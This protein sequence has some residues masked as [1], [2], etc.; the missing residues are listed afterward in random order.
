MSVHFIYN[1]IFHNSDYDYYK[2]ISV[3]IKTKT[4][5]ITQSLISDCEKFRYFKRFSV[6]SDNEI[7]EMIHILNNN[8]YS[9]EF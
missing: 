4:Y 2:F 5:T 3:D 1:K 6:L 9:M 7:S 8:G